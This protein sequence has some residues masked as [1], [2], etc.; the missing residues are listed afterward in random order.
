MNILEVED[1]IKG[2]PDESLFREAQQPTGQVPQFLVISEIQR[3]SDMRRRYQAQQERPQATVKDQIMQEGI[4]GMVPQQMRQDLGGAPQQPPQPPAMPQQQMGMPAQPGGMGAPAGAPMQAPVQMKEGGIVKMQNMGQVP[5]VSGGL[6]TNLEA[7]LAGIE[8]E[9]AS[10]GPYSGR[11][12]PFGRVGVISPESEEKYARI[13]QLENLRRDIQRRLGLAGRLSE[14]EPGSEL[15]PARLAGSFRESPAL[16]RIRDEDLGVLAGMES[17]LTID[18]TVAAAASTAAAAQPQGIASLSQDDVIEAGLQYTGPSQVAAGAP[19]QARSQQSAPP[20]QAAPRQTAPAPLAGA[21]GTGLPFTTQ[22]LIEGAV[23]PG[24]DPAMMGLRNLLAAQEQRQSVSYDEYKKK[25]EARSGTRMEEAEARVKELLGEAE[26]ETGQLS[27]EARRD[28]MAQALIQFGAGI[29]GGD[30]SSGLEKAGT[31]AYA[32]TA[33]ARDE[34]RDRMREARKEG[35]ST[36]DAARAAADGAF[37]TML[38]LDMKTEEGRVAA[39]NALQDSRN[40]ILTAMAER[41]GGIESERR[42]MFANLART[43]AA[44]EQAAITRLTD[45]AKTEGLNKRAVL[46]LVQDVLKDNSSLLPPD[47]GANE[48]GDL[49]ANMA[50]SLAFKLGIDIGELPDGNVSQESDNEFAGFSATRIK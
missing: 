32:I 33:K 19:A 26:K 15:P 44:I 1:M 14:M 5:T 36:M 30:I 22:Q 41:A 7:Q 28:A 3:R 43:T 40:S 48:I 47:A 23:Q 39:A 8:N 31:T 37:N 46:D 12:G 2:M 9:L 35:R 38:G 34:A 29:A 11:F 20:A 24:I 18:P 50:T 6:I 27:K 17:R 4:G 42:S 21:G 13:D 45:L 10:L 25:I 49:V 16:A